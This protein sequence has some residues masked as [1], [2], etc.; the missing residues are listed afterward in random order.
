MISCEQYDYVE[1]ACMYNYP[2]KL[3]LKSGC[4]LKGIAYD[5]QRNEIREECLKLKADKTEHLIVLD[6]ISRMEVLVENPHF[7]AVNFD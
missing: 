2:I 1:I 7:R 6:T 5:T 4:E 3:I